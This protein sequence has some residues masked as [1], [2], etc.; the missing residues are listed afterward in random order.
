[1]TVKHALHFSNHLDRG[2]VLISR[3]ISPL[4]ES[5]WR[6]I[7]FAIKR[8]KV[9]R[10]HHRCVYRL[11]NR[12]RRKLK[13]D[14]VNNANSAFIFLLNLLIGQDCQGGLIGQCGQGGPG[15][16][17]RLDCHGGQTGQAGQGVQDGKDIHWIRVVRLVR[18][19]R[20]VWVVKVIQVVVR[21][22]RDVQV[23]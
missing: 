13:L 1:M 22:V 7:E 10:Q 9:H 6:E 11:F 17:G 12:S 3:E 20:V 16:S 23:V 18:I 5:I 15:G 4:L 14:Q 21:M 8:E 19:V 2:W